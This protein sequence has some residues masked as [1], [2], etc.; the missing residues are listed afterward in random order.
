METKVSLPARVVNGV[1][2]TYV[3]ITHTFN[4]TWHA[5]VIDPSSM[6]TDAGK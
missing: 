2:H 3:E 5:L 4:L 6:V 1:P